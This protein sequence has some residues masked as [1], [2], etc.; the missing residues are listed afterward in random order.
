MLAVLVAGAADARAELLRLHAWPHAVPVVI[1]GAIGEWAGSEPVVVPLSGEGGADSVELR[2]AVFDGWIYLAAVWA[3]STCN[4][5]HK[6]YRW[7]PAEG[8]YVKT[9][10]M[11]DRFAI[12]FEL[13]GAF[14]ANKIDGSLFSADVWHWKANRTNPV[15]LAHDKHWSVTDQPSEAARPFHAPDGRTIYLMRPS[16][17]GDQL[18]KQARPVLR[19]GDLEPSYEVNPHAAGSVADVRARGRCAD[20]R[21]TL[22]LGRALATGHPDDVE[23]PASGRLRFAVAVFDGVSFNRVDGGTHSHSEIVE[24]ATGAGV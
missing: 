11:E 24:L 2:A 18:Y 14:T 21:W 10:I 16:D 17:D 5:L 1:D 9:E 7:D 8:R 15:G 3:D 13:D 12:S 23:I 20:G 6:P 4:E 19:R 22:E